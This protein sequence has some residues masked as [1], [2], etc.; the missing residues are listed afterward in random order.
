MLVPVAS[1]RLKIIILRLIVS[2]KMETVLTG[3]PSNWSYY[4]ICR[5]DPF[6][7]VRII[8]ISYFFSIGFLGVDYNSDLLYRSEPDRLFRQWIRN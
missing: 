7:K 5:Y 8:S 6:Y 4:A 3:R 1:V 2:V